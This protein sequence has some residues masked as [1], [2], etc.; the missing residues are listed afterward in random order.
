MD[1]LINIIILRPTLSAAGPFWLLGVAIWGA[2]SVHFNIL[3]HH[4]GSGADPGGPFCH[5]GS[6]LEDNGTSRMDSKC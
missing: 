2:W 3:G 4:F 5:L 6:T 1:T